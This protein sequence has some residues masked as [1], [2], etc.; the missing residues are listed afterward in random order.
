MDKINWSS[1]GIGAVITLCMGLFVYWLAPKIF[2]RSG[3]RSRL[4]RS[5]TPPTERGESTTETFEG[6][7][8]YTRE[9]TSEGEKT[10]TR[11]TF[12]FESEDEHGEYRAIE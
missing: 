10:T 1:I 2:R 9:V 7:R 12:H 6:V 5:R 4:Y 11:E 3:P 8:T